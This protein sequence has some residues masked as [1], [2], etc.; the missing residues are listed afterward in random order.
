VVT[1]PFAN[2]FSLTCWNEL[3]LF[4]AKF[5]LHCVLA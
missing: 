5:R 1:S 4:N 2:T 3:L